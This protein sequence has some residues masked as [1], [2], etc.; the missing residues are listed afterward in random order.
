MTS[1]SVTAS[2]Q[3]LRPSRLFSPPVCASCLFPKMRW[4]KDEEACGG[5]SYSEATVMMPYK[6]TLCTANRSE[7]SYLTKNRNSLVRICRRSFPF[8]FLTHQENSFEQF[9][10]NYVSE[11]LQQVLL[12]LTLKIEQVWVLCVWC[13][14]R[15]R[16][17]PVVFV[18]CYDNALTERVAGDL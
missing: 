5:D 10:I 4:R 12:E 15:L 6:Y 8:S 11:K 16:R 2:S 9:V 17:L 18:T 13:L 3:V 14:L 7:A 1:I